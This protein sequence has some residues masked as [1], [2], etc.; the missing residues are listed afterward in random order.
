VSV[1]AKTTSKQHGR[2]LVYG[3]QPN[4]RFH[5]FYLPPGSCYLRGNTWVCLDELYELDHKIILQKRFDGK[6][7]PVCDLLPK[8]IRPIQDCAL[9]SLDVT[10][11]QHAIISTC[12]I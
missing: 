10:P 3:C 12:L 9:I 8:V 11:A 4:D 1:V 6:I 7:K 5:N 2:G